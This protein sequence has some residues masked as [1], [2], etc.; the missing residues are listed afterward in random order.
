MTRD[1]S[2]EEPC[3]A[4]VACTVV[5]PAKA[6]VVRRRQTSQGTR[7]SP[8]A[9][10][11][12]GRESNLLKPLD[13]LILGMG[14]SLQ[15][16]AHANAQVA[17]QVRSP[18]GRAGNREGEGSRDRRRLADAADH[19]GGVGATAW[20]HGH[21]EPLAKPSASRRDIG[22]RKGGCLTG[23]PG[24]QPKTRGWRRGPSEWCSGGRPVERRDPTVRHTFDNM[25]GR[26]AMTK[27]PITLHDLRRRRDAKAKAAPSWRCWGLYVHICTPETLGQGQQRRAWG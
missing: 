27:T 4:K 20:G 5:C 18:G 1:H 22:G 8:G 15:A 11:A 13:S 19:S 16:V 7:Q 26:G 24:N 17:P 2:T 6:G 12:G 14:A 9:R 25:G 21:A 10:S 23:P 3:A